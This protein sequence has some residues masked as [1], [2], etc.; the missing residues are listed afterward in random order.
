[1][2]GLTCP[3]AR[4]PSSP[5]TTLAPTG[6][7]PQAWQNVP[8]RLSPSPAPP[9][10]KQNCAINHQGR[11][12]GVASLDRSPALSLSFPS[13][14]SSGIPTRSP[15]SSCFPTTFLPPLPENPCK[16][17]LAL[18]PCSPL[19]STPAPDTR[20]S[21]GLHSDPEDPM[22]RPTEASEL[23]RL[24]G[25]PWLHHITSANSNNSLCTR[26]HPKLLQI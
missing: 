8:C 23:H 11:H 26:H 6:S 5:A 19:P 14:F 7:V 12:R 20:P 2:L 13:R 10:G 22:V 17:L 21:S 25:M 24:E 16:R 15:H 18:V 4:P 9:G 3:E 1:M